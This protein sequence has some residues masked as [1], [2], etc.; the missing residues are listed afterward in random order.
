MTPVRELS[1]LRR[2]HDAE[3]ERIH[4]WPESSPWIRRAVAALPRDRFAPDRLWQW[5]GHAYVPVDRDIDPGQWAG[6]VYGSLYEAAVTQVIGG[7]ATSSLSCESVVADMLDCLDVRP[8]HRVLE[9][10]TG[11]GRNAA[12]LA[13]RA[14]PG[15][16]VSIETDPDLA[17]HARQ[18]LKKT[19]AD[20]HVVV[21]DGAQGRP[22]AEPFEPFDRVI[23]TYAVDTV[24]WAWVEQTRPGGRIVTPWGHLGLVSLTVAGDGNSARG[25]VQGLAQFMP[26]RGSSGGPEGD[27]SRVRAGRKPEHE[28]HA[29]L[30][31]S[32]LHTDWHLRFALRVLLP[33]VH[34]AG[35]T[36]DDGTS[37]WLNDSTSSWAAFYAQDDGGVLVCEGGPRRLAGEVRKAWDWWTAAGEPALY[38]WGMT[39]A[40][41]RQWMWVGEESV[42]APVLTAGA[43][44]VGE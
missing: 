24:P 19:G 7:L 14:G 40:L 15:R 9:L 12:L 31:L 27:F 26:A 28:H 37:V 22:R 43:E 23:S 17:E 25:H 38:D 29:R 36:D 11:T 4:G 41:E 8:G 39:V 20:V 18:R 44:P 16:V 30:G 5:D 1:S 35:S 42:V 6:L 13:H 2:A 21:G 32:P 3:M 34:I 33:D 10:G